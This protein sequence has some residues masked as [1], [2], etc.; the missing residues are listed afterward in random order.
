VAGLL[1]QERLPVVAGKMNLLKEQWKKVGCTLPYMGF[2]LLPLS[3]IPDFRL[4]DC[5]LVDVGT[6]TKVP[7]FE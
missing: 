4:T 3:V 1:S 2:N 6:A 5:G 7:L